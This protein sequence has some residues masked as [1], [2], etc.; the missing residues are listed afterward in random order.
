M[1]PVHTNIEIT[2]H[3]EKGKR[4]ILWYANRRESP[5][6]ITTGAKTIS[7]ALVNLAILIAEEE[8]KPDEQQ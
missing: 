5:F 1:M 7:D 8:R 3:Y 2:P 6:S 4:T